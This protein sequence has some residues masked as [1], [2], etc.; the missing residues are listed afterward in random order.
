MSEDQ[1][2]HNIAGDDIF[3]E[4]R[5]RIMSHFGIA[6]VVLGMPFS[7][8]DLIEG[9]IVMGLAIFGMLSIIALNALWIFYKKRNVIPTP[10]VIVSV[11]FVVGI[12][13]F[14]RGSPG[15]FGRI[16]H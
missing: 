11:M 7:V 16:R 8:G 1:F 13:I 14:H 9:K 5:D 6:A 10:A 12:A 4:Y 2:K 15:F 3:E